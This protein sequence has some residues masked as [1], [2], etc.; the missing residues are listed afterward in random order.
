MIFVPV[1]CFPQSQ[2]NN[3]YFGNNA[4]LNFGNGEVSILENGAMQ[5]AAGCATISDKDGNLLLYTDGQTVWNKNHQ[6]MENGEDLVGE[7]AGI[8]SAI[9]IPKPNDSSTYFIF[10][11]RE[12]VETSPIYYLSGVFYSE[13]KFD[14]QHPLGYVKTNKNIRIAE[15][16]ATSK[17]ASIYHPETNTYRV[18]TI[19][20]D[21]PVFGVII[22]DD[23]YIFRIFNVTEM[24]IN[25]TPVKVQ[26]N[27]GIERV[28]AMKISPDGTFLAFADSANEKIYF[29]NYDNQAV[30]FSPYYTLPTIP[31]FGVTLTTYGIEFSQDSN[32]FYYSG[33]NNI[34]QFPFKAIN[35]SE[36]FE[37]Y[38][39]PIANPGSMQ[40][41]RNGKIYI[42]QG[43]SDNPTGHIAVIHKPEKVGSDCNFQPIAIQFENAS[44]TKGLPIFI[45]SE[46]RNRIIPSDDDCVDKPF[47]F[48][49]DAYSEIQ[50]VFWDFGDGGTS[51][52]LN[53]TYTFVNSGI[54]KVKATIVINNELIAL[55]KDVEAYPLPFLL[56]NQILSQCDVDN[57][58]Q[59]VFNLEN[60]KSFITDGSEFEYTFY[61]SST[62]AI[63]EIDSIQNPLSY[64]NIANPEQIFVKMVTPNGCTSIANFSLENYT[65]NI[66][67]IQDF[68]VCE[69]SDGIINNA[70]GTFNLSEIK[71]EIIDS[72]GLGT[73][74]NIT[75]YPTL[76]NAQ[77]KIDAFDRY[78]TGEST[79]IWVRIEDENFNCFGVIPFNA[80]VNSTITLDIDKKYTICDPSLQPTIVLDGG[81]NNDTWIW[82][83]QS[84]ATV[85]TQR[86]FQL[87][88][89][90]NFSVTVEKQENG[91]TCTLTKSFIVN[92]ITNPEFL[93]VNAGDGT[94]YV[95][96]KG[97]SNYEFSL[98]GVTYSGS[99]TSNTF[100]EV[101]AGV[102]TV[103]VRDVNLCEKTL[104]VEVY[105]LNIPKYFTPNNDSYNDIWN[106]KGLSDQ[107][108]SKAEIL[109]FDRYSRLLHKMNLYDNE[110]GWDGIYNNQILPASDYW[111]KVTLTDLQNNAIVKRGHFSLLR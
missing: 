111:Y 45:A 23:R 3:W 27:Q 94:I 76:L 57:D 106:I 89:P 62:D 4:G 102:Q 47:T 61:H 64:E 71:N 100:G 25:L 2:T 97:N 43:N 72:F 5:T 79:V 13:I 14:I 55:Y 63:S 98:D 32:M 6:I 21:D 70:E 16:L 35:D 96:I 105:L 24:G 39:M 60:I 101:A 69:D 77:T 56:P 103:Y 9:I 99:G 73:G 53:P 85:S 86:L 66:Q 74:F 10:Y 49:L 46:L 33:G 30:T 22:P 7:R 78:Y 107:F 26:I 80:I 87:S 108:Y 51:T 68:F 15:V 1:F 17:L 90:G 52:D 50:S 40:L 110:V 12:N 8:Q 36:P 59:S 93:D 81:I 37:F 104:S 48:E 58:G 44:S 91:L 65:P 18:I 67:P 28:G 19:T 38:A 41:A 83:N 20:K 88:Q 54:N 11:T 92:G 82:K 42:A 95:S 109:I 34:I 75:F 84:G 31:A 29:Y